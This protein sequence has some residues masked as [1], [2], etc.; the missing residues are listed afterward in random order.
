VLSSALAR[1]S[2]ELA[3]SSDA[4]FDGFLSPA[5]ISTTAAVVFAL[6]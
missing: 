4:P 1:Q 5:D 6:I 2:S 3:F